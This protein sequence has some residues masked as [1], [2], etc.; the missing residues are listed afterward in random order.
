L[1]W[2]SSVALVLAGC[3]Q[4]FGNAPVQGIDA[5]FFDATIDAMPTCP[6]GAA[7]SYSRDFF[8][9]LVEDCASIT[10]AD[11]NML[12]L[13]G[14]NSQSYPSYGPIGEALVPEPSLLVTFQSEA[15]LSRDGQRVSFVL[16]STGRLL[17][18][19][20]SGSSWV[21]DPDI[22]TGAPISGASEISN[23]PN[24]R[25]LVSYADGLHELVEQGGTWTD[26]AT[27]VLEPSFVVTGPHLSGDALRV[28]FSTEKST[29]YFDRSA[30]DVTFTPRGTIGGAEGLDDADLTDDCGLMYFATLERIWVAHP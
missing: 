15:R 4:V 11:G 10:V 25:V 29:Y 21:N 13:C 28:W 14:V 16:V 18:F 20:R 3:N 19:H 7:P 22:V 23:G 5:A 27:H 26:V 24:A 1:R 30:L 2:A 17:L 9:L 6:I 12:A 8:Q